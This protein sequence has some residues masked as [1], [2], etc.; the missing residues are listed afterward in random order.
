MYFIGRKVINVIDSFLIM[1][2][3]IF[4]VISAIF[5]VPKTITHAQNKKELEIRKSQLNDIVVFEDSQAYYIHEI[6]DFEETILRTDDDLHM[7]NVNGQ[8]VKKFIEWSDYKG[9]V[10]K[11]DDESRIIVDLIPA[12]PLDDK[13]SERI[14]NMI[15]E[16]REYERQRQREIENEKHYNAYKKANLNNERVQNTRTFETSL[17]NYGNKLEKAYK[18]NS[19]HV[20][21]NI[22]AIEDTLSQYARQ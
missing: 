5:I 19:H 14:F 10:D 15:T 3:G 22:K 8:D 20:N 4:I 17:S 12:S 6:L 16:T 7:K 9:N 13:T 1:I 21:D 2:A 11:L 18:T